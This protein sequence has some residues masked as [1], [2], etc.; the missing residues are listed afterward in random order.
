MG[1]VEVMQLRSASEGKSKG[2]DYRGM[3]RYLVTLPSFRNRQVFLDDSRI[4]PV[5]DALRA[6]AM[7][8]EFDV[9][10]SSRQC[11]TCPYRSVLPV[12]GVLFRRCGAAAAGSSPSL[13]PPQGPSSG[14]PAQ[15]MGASG[16]EA[17]SAAPPFPSVAALPIAPG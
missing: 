4:T 17:V 16:W 10:A 6:L 2:F 11:G 14:A 12:S 3:H 7:E 15:A 8:H 1:T 5:L 13:R 9:F